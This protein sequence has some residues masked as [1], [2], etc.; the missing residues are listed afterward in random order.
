MNIEFPN[1][2]EK[3]PMNSPQDNVYDFQKAVARY[4]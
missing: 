3:K 1:V 2:H 4:E